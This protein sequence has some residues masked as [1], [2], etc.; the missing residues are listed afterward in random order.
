MDI[1]I[2]NDVNQ[3]LIEETKKYKSIGSS[4]PIKQF[5]SKPITVEAN[6]KYHI[7]AIFKGGST[8]FGTNYKPTVQSD[9]KD[10]FTVT[11]FESDHDTEENVVAKGQFPS[12]YFVKYSTI[13]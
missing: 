12:L 10:P 13:I 11:F 3:C 6:K 9:D 8:Y 5:F 1:K 4:K 7:T 2:Y